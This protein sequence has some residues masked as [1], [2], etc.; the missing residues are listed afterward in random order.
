MMIPKKHMEQDGLILDSPQHWETWTG[1][2]YLNIKRTRGHTWSDAVIRIPTDI[3]RHL[4]LKHKD[5]VIA[6]IKLP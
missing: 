6:A 2:V 1:K 3:A 4:K 5:Q